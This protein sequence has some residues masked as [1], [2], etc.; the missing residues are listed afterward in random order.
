LLRR[1]NGGKVGGGGGARNETFLTGGWALRPRGRKL[2]QK[3]KRKTKKGRHRAKTPSMYGGGV[4][5]DRRRMSYRAK[6]KEKKRKESPE[7]D[8]CYTWGNGKTRKQ[9]GR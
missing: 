6:K 3:V 5:M 4:G 9:E 2:Q 8:L 7:G 1:P